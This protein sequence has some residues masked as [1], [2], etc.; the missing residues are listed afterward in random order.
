MLCSAHLWILRPATYR[1]YAPPRHLWMLCSAHLWI[2]R[3]ATYGS[4]APPP[5]DPTP[6]HLWILR[7]G[8]LWILRQATYGSYARPPMDLTPGLHMDLTR[9]HMDP[10]PRG[11][12]AGSGC[13]VYII[14]EPTNKF[15]FLERYTCRFCGIYKIWI[16]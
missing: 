2:L 9:L 11:L 12:S 10:T 1:S 14:L 4:Y 7:P 3:P 5:M 8:H 13:S 16:F 15:R 6:R